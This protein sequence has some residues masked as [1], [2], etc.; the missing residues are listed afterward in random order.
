[1]QPLI[2]DNTA[3]TIVARVMLRILFVF[4]GQLRDLTRVARI[5]YKPRP[6]LDLQNTHQPCRVIS[7]V[8]WAPAWMLRKTGEGVSV[9]NLRAVGQFGGRSENIAR[10]PTEPRTR[11]H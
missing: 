4:I 9:P 2:R 11:A 10:K 6:R 1:M 3:A 5:G 8:I 7:A